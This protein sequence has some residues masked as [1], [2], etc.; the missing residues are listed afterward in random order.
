MLAGPLALTLAQLGYALGG[1][2]AGQLIQLVVAAAKLS[3]RVVAAGFLQ[4]GFGQKL[5]GWHSIEQV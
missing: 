5:G 3:Q 1:R 2:L 4:G